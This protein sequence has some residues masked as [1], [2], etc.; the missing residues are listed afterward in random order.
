M[1]GGE[2]SSIKWSACAP[3]SACTVHDQVKVFIFVIMKL[4]S[5]AV[6]CLAQKQEV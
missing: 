1:S 5:A 6:F 4:K 2:P 3:Q